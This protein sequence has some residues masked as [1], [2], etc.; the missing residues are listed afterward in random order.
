MKQKIPRPLAATA[1]MASLLLAGCASFSSDG[2][3]DKVAELTQERT[4]HPAR[5][6]RVDAELQDARSRVAQVLKVPLTADT[7]VEIALLNNRGLQARFGQLGIA[8]SELVR[9][10]RLRNPAF[11]FGRMTG[12]GSVEIERSVLFDVLGLLTLPLATEVAQRGFEQAQYQAAYDAVGLVAD[13]RRAYFDAVAAQELV[14]FFQQ[15]K[16]AADVANELAKRMLQAGNISKLARMREQA[17]YADATAQLARAQHQAA[18]ERERLTRLLGLQGAEL[19]FRLPD[20]LPDLPGQPTEPRNAEQ[21]AMDKRLDVLMARRSAEATARALGLTKATRLVNVLEVG[22]RN[23]SE[24]G[25]PRAG[26][27]EIELELPIFDF[28]AARAARAE[29]TYMR[30]VN[31]TA[32]VAV[33]ARSEV[34]EAYSAYRTSFDLAK[35]YR[36]EV[37]PLRKRISEENLLRYNGMLISVFELLADAREQVAGVT[38]AVQALRD[39]WVADTNLQTALTGRSPAAG[40]L[41]PA[42]PAAGAAPAQ[43]H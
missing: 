37:V 4:G 13:T 32:E 3:F 10:G 16:E 1:A 25:N 35:H 8:E 21:V 39:F 24:S 26:G 43:G 2:G 23:K 11:S 12:G 41:S 6:Q 30:A 14:K 9:A 15:V 20:R 28:G 5:A 17:F 22:Y 33:N 42:S 38:G 34:R 31:R 7:A 27:Y 29:A 40:S 19:D 36:D 18:A